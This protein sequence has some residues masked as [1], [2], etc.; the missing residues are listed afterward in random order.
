ME[1]AGPDLFDVL[2]LFPMGF[3]EKHLERLA[4]QLLEVVAFIHREEY[5]HRDIKAENICLR[6]ARPTTRDQ[7]PDTGAAAVL[8]ADFCL[9]DFGMAC[10]S[11]ATS[12]ENEFNGSPGFF[13]PEMQL[14]NKQYNPIEADAFSCGAVLLEAATGSAAFEE[15][16][17][18]AYDA[19]SILAVPSVFEPNLRKALAAVGANDA[20]RNAR[21]RKLILDLMTVDPGDRLTVEE[22][23][24]HD[25]FPSPVVPTWAAATGVPT[26]DALSS[27]SLAAMAALGGGGRGGLPA[28]AAAA[29]STSDD[30]FSRSTPLPQI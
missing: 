24:G 28:A 3:P 21:A 25:F 9:V 10:P 14:G 26:G 27:G 6:P 7:L 12:L 4:A 16:W 20:F 11:T 17:M 22:A 30:R 15:L 5:A 8:S 29:P 2:P 23:C 18:C 19:E 13:A 1:N